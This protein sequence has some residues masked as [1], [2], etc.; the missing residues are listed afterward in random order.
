MRIGRHLVPK[1]KKIFEKQGFIFLFILF[2]F[3][4]YMYFFND[5]SMYF[6]CVKETMVCTYGHSTEYNKTVRPVETYNFSQITHAKVARHRRYKGS[7]YYTVEMFGRKGKVFK[8]PHD[9]SSEHEA[10]NEAKKFNR[11]LTSSLNNYA[12]I[13]LP[14]EISATLLF[15]LVSLI[16][17]AV[18]LFSFLK[19]L[20]NTAGNAAKYP[21]IS[22]MDE[23]IRKDLKEEGMSDEEITAFLKELNE[24]ADNHVKT[25]YTNQ[26][27][28]VIQ[29]NREI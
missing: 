4:G 13:D 12:Y 9:F 23:E 27:E 20:K 29:R 22:D 25:V 21:E 1:N 3:N 7:S 28:D 6:E 26:N 8:I 24:D 5:R 10:L 14:P 19:D 18:I 2:V 16:L 17:A 15:F 11:F